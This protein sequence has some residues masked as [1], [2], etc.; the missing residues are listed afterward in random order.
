M[1]PSSSD[2]ASRE[3][4]VNTLTNEVIDAMTKTEL[5]AELEGKTEFTAKAIR[6]MTHKCLVDVLVSLQPKPEVVVKVTVKKGKT[7]LPC[8]C[9]CLNESGEPMMTKGGRFLPGHDARYYATLTPS[10]HAP[11]E[12]RCGCGEM[13][14]GGFYRPGHDAKHFSLLLKVSRGME[15]T[16]VNNP[17]HSAQGRLMKL[18]A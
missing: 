6:R 16:P 12:C 8:G 7:P 15:A 14:K 4:T 18:T 1:T 5:V 13:T 9:G 17:T 3:H 10:K 11:K 2:L